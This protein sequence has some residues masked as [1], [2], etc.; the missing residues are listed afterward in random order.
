MLLMGTPHTR[1]GKKH[2]PSDTQAVRCHWLR[3][4]SL[5]LEG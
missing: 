2:S 4:N 1:Q 3:E 5:A